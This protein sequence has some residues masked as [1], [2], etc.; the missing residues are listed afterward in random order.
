MNL[1]RSGREMAMTMNIQDVGKAAQLKNLAFV[2]A[3]L[4]VTG[5]VGGW[6]ISTTLAK[7]A[8]A[9]EAET[10]N[11]IPKLSL[12]KSKSHLVGFYVVIGTDPEGTPYPGSSVLDISLAPSGALELA[13]DNGKVVGVGQL[14]GNVL[15]V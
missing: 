3:A 8:A 11:D 4:L 1:G 7:S 5:A 14:V 10:R 13:W 9:I 2:A 6:G 15:A 12:E